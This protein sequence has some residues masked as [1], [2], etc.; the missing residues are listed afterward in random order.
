MEGSS[1]K[2]ASENMAVSLRICHN[3]FRT[4]SP[5]FHLMF[6]NMVSII[7]EVFIVVFYLFFFYSWVVKACLTDCALQIFVTLLSLTENSFR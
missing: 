6:F 3:S 2:T 4:G 1:P 5:K 7:I